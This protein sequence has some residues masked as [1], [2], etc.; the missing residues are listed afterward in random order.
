[1]FIGAHVT[2]AA[3]APFEFHGMLMFGLSK[4]ER[5]E[6]AV[7]SSLSAMFG[8][9]DTGEELVAGIK[10]RYAQHW[11]GIIRE[12]LELGNSADFTAAAV[13]SIFYRDMIATEIAQDLLVEAREAI[14]NH[15]YDSESGLITRL[16]FST[17]FISSLAAKLSQDQKALWLRD[18][19]R[20]I[21]ADDDLHVDDTIKYL[22]GRADRLRK[23]FKELKSSKA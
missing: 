19:H 17:V 14:L 15:N 9:G 21:F 23:E 16:T 2:I 6:S 20:A 11:Q 10:L 18:I 4:A 3:S 13:T 7:R 5:Y 12:G 8:A 1:M 22:L